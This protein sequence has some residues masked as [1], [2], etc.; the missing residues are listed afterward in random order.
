[1]G[2]TP[3]EAYSANSGLAWANISCKALNV[4]G[5]VT[6]FLMVRKYTARRKDQLGLG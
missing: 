1:V 2:T 3:W 5:P 4:N 6:N